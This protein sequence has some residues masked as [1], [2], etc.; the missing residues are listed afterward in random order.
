MSFENWN[1]SD[2]IEAELINNIIIVDKILES[3]GYDITPE[4]HILG[5]AGL[6]LNGINYNSTLDIDTANRIDSRIRE[7]IELF[8]NDAASE[9]VILPI[10]YKKRLI[11]FKPEMFN[12]I[13]VFTLSNEDIVFTKLTSDRN[14]DLDQLKNTNILSK[15]NISL[16]KEI[17]DTELNNPI[18]KL[19][20]NSKLNS[21]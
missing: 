13:K 14:K 6:I 3:I 19:R 12:S 15:T 2:S 20:I 7:E 10:N 5:G 21:L 9:V 17:I 11:P 18:L 8:I 16:L 1:T 4:F